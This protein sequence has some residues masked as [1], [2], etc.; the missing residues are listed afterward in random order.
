MI[1]AGSRDGVRAGMLAVYNNQLAGRVSEAGPLTSRVQLVTDPAFRA[2]AVAVPRTYTG[3]PLS[4]RHVG[5]YKGTSGEKGRLEWLTDDAP[6][7]A[8]AYVLTTEDPLNGVPSGLV[9]GRVASLAS[10][11]GAS[12][13]VEVEPVLNSRGLEHVMILLGPEEP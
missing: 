8:G 3:V 11:R 5:L 13:R 12:P 1:A 4:E 9:L 6:V 2:G 10:E 7:E